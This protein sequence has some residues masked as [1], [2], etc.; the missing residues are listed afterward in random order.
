MPFTKKIP[1][2][3]PETFPSDLPVIPQVDIEMMDDTVYHAVFETDNDTHNFQSMLRH[4]PETAVGIKEAD[5]EGYRNVVIG[6]IRSTKVVSSMTQPTV[7]LAQ[8]GRVPLT[9]SNLAYARYD[10]ATHELTIDFRSK[11]SYAYADVP[12]DIYT[13]LIHAPSAGKYFDSRIRGKY[14]EREVTA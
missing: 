1:S 3:A 6:N 8:G 2:V 10:D 9:G 11:R 5:G 14:V 7:P 13:E 12:Q 4:T